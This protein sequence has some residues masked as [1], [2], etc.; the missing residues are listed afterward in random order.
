MKDG[1]EYVREAE[2]HLAGMQVS[3]ALVGFGRAEEAGFD[4]DECASGRWTCH[5]LMGD[6]ERA[7]RES[8]AISERGNPDPQRYW[9][10]SALDGRNVLVRCLHGLGDTLQ[11]I[12]Y[13]P[14]LR[15][16]A[17]CVT[18]EAQPSL[19]RL[20]A[21]SGLADAVITW[22]D[23][24]PAWDRQIEVVEL[25]R[26]FRTQLSSIPD[27]VPYLSTASNGTTGRRADGNRLRVGVVWNSSKYNPA[28]SIRAQQFAKVFEVRQA[29]FFSLQ[30]GPERFELAYGGRPIRDLYREEWDVLDTAG[31]LATLDLVITVDTMM[32]HLA[33]GLGVPVWTL[34]PHQ[35]DWRWMLDREDSPWYP[36]MRLIRQKRAGDW[37]AVVERVKED[38]QRLTAESLGVSR[39]SG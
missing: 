13:A 19:K 22:G 2:E 14:L 3:E 25:P 10:G 11:F 15:K 9:D 30:A 35:C 7:W 4:A 8:D 34:L 31:A 29:E 5:M 28:R 1:G 39:R 32:A 24:E 36:T 27:K 38:L 6:F 12:R 17:Q 20:L 16:R 26:I 33:G 23:A 37:G 18:I 21:V